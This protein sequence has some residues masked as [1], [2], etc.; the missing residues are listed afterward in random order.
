MAAPALAASIEASAICLGVVGTPGWRPNVSPEPVTAHVMKTS[1][2]IRRHAPR[3]PANRDRSVA[4]P[5]VRAQSDRR[6]GGGS[7][8][9]H[10]RRAL[11]RTG[12]ATKNLAAAPRRD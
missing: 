1:W 2:F 10:L 12:P 7:Q 5:N 4:A 11:S 3:R 8:V 6:Q 9:V